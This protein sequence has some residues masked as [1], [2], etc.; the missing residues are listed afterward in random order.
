MTVNQDLNDFTV[1]ICTYNGEKRL[2]EVLDKLRSQ[3]NTENLSWEVIVIDNNS[4]DNTAKIVQEYQTNWSS[5]NPLRYCLETE[6]GLGY[7]R[8]RA[9]AESGAEL[10]GFL[11]DDNLPQPDWVAAAYAFAQEHPKAG[12]YGSK[13]SADYEMQ[14][15]ENFHRI[16]A[17][18]A[19]TERGSSPLLYNPQT[20]LLP[21]GAGIVVRKQAWLSS[22]PGQCILAGRIKG[23]MLAGEDLEV[24]YHIQK[25]G[26]EIWYNPAMHLY[27]KIP[28]HRLQKDY[29]IPLFR[30]IGHCRYATRMIGVKF[31]L[32]PIFTI[33][34][35]L[36]DLKKIIFH[37]LKHRTKAQKDLVLACE[38]QLMKSSLISPF[39]LWK[40]GYL[41]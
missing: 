30:G 23:D 35:I 13:I 27:H 32:K 19:I 39:Y 20:K 6:Q 24:L 26:W 18:L 11:D 17:F 28:S 14:P 21:P 29:L 40:K 15:P 34:Y 5:K 9:I 1:A 41:D 16:A 33:A 2:P 31:W 22:V 12:A 4:S 7:A 10:I 37:L 8:K 25:L 36:N 3:I 38:L